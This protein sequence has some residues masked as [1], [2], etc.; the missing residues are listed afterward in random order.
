MDEVQPGL[1]GHGIRE[2]DRNREVPGSDEVAVLVVAIAEV[3][4]DLDR[5]AN[6]PHA[7]DKLANEIAKY[8]TQLEFREAL[9]TL[10]LDPYLATPSEYAELLKA[11]M[12]W[13]ADTINVLKKK[14]VKFDF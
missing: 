12:A 1:L 11:A 9:L 4:S 8:V 14:G 3:Q 13:N 6:G 10:G 2:A 7:V 5:L